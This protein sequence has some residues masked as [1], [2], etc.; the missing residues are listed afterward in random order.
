MAKESKGRSLVIVESPTKARTISK[1]LGKGFEVLASNGHIRD[2][3]DSAAEIPAKLKKE[4]WA[5]LGINIDAEFET[6]YVVPRSKKNQVK[7]LRAAVQGADVIYLA[8][9]EDREGE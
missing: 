7:E 6:L 8:T 1:F 2:L 4:P 5:R 9:D 3:P